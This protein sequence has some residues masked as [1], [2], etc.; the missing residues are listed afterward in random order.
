MPD[1]RNMMSGMKLPSFDFD[2]RDLANNLTVV[3]QTRKVFT[4]R[5]FEAGQDLIQS[6]GIGAHHPVILVPG[7]VS[8]G[9][10]SWSTTE[11]NKG[12]FRKRLWG[13]STMIQAVL[14][15]KK[16]WIEAISLDPETGLDPVG[17][18]VR[19]AQGLDAASEFIQGYWVRRLY[20]FLT[21][22]YSASSSAGMATDCAKPGGDRL[23]H[24]RNGNGILRLATILHEPRNSRR[25]FHPTQEDDRNVQKNNRSEISP[26]QS[27]YGC[28]C[29]HVLLEMG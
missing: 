21:S 12:F 15:D 2:L 26:D 11:E 8:T 28:H 25:V 9:L 6:E 24:K 18:K 20:A 27:L 23:R 3:Q 1:V 13:T 5:N 16:R 14:S 19:A 7:I 29:R 10:E 17:H 22:A 4:N